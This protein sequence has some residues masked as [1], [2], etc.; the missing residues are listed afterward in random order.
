MALD[1]DELYVMNEFMKGRLIVD[2]NISNIKSIVLLC[3]FREFGFLNEYY[4]ISN[5][6]G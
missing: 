3:N 4:S 5:F 6:K 1:H 2:M